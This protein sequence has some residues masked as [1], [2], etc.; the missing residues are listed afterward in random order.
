MSRLM[1]ALYDHD[2]KVAVGI[3]YNTGRAAVPLSPQQAW[4]TPRA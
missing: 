3:D 1:V 4:T 2:T